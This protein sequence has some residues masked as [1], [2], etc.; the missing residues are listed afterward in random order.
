MKIEIIKK[1]SV[2]TVPKPEKE[3]GPGYGEQTNTRFIWSFDGK[4]CHVAPTS[5]PEKG[6]G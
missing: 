2:V 5:K 1:A 6:R 4:P 3:K